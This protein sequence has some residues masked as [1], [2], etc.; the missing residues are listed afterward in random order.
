M[1]MRPVKI[2]LES[3]RASA[4]VAGLWTEQRSAA[5]GD[6]TLSGCPHFEAGGRRFAQRQTLGE[7]RRNPIT[8]IEESVCQAFCIWVSKVLGRSIFVT[9]VDL[10][11]IE[12]Y[13]AMDDRV[14]DRRSIRGAESWAEAPPS[15]R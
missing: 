7:R 14:P 4:H 15:R 5:H 13:S 10:V 12:R 9:E 2:D 11:V 1:C 3:G 6:G 8:G